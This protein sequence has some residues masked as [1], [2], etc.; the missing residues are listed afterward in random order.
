MRPYGVC[1]KT[2]A[3]VGTIDH[4]IAQL[5]NPSS[6]RRMWVKEIHVFKQGAA[7]AADEP[8]VRRTT[9]RGTAGSTV[10]PTIRND[11]ENDLASPAGALLDLA[12][13]TVQ[14]T[15]TAGEG[16]AGLVTAAAVSAGWMWVFSEPGIVVPG[17][18]G[19]ALCLGIALAFPASR[20]TYIWS[21]Q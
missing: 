2:A 10:T 7:G 21:E 3:T 18:S 12:A 9:A 1:G 17:G 13:F 19:L 11:F 16:I 6:V 4:A 15:S 5:W 8:L 20:V 14:P